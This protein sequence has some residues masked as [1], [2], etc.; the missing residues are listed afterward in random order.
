MKRRIT[1]LLTTLAAVAVL[2]W[3]TVAFAAGW[4]PY[5]TGIADVGWNSDCRFDTLQLVYYKNNNSS[6]VTLKKAGQY[7]RP[8]GTC[9]IN[10]GQMYVENGD[11]TR[12]T[13]LM[14]YFPDPV[15]PGDRWTVWWNQGEYAYDKDGSHVLSATQAGPNGPS[16]ILAG[17]G[18]FFL[19]DGSFEVDVYN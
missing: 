8:T 9:A 18:I 14:A 17:H 13:H 7:I 2:G 6:S 10:G 12:P 5:G 11:G 16:G 1:L 4:T 15:E 19:E 3:S